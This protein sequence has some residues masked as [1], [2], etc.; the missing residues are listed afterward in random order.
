MKYSII[1]NL[2]FL[3]NALKERKNVP[4]V[5][6]ASTIKM[7]LPILPVATSSYIIY[8]LTSDIPLKHILLSTCGLLVVTGFLN[9]LD[10]TLQEILQSNSKLAQDKFVQLIGRKIFTTDYQNLESEH[11][12]T[13]MSKI[14]SQ[15]FRPDSN[16]N[17]IFISLSQVG[18]VG[19]SLLFYASLLMKLNPFIILVVIFSAIFHFY[20][21]KQRNIQEKELREAEAKPE[22]IRNH[23]SRY[24]SDYSSAKDIRIYGLSS[25]FMNKFDS[26]MKESIDIMKCDN[27]KRGKIE[28][29]VGLITFIRDLLCYGF[30]AKLLINN[31][32]TASDFVFY[33]GVIGI[34]AVSVYDVSNKL[35][36]IENLNSILSEFRSFIDIPDRLNRDKGIPLPKKDFSITLKDLSFRYPNNEEDT[37]KNLNL[38]IKNGEKI[39]IVGL[40]GAGKTTLVKLLCGFYEITSGEIL[41]GGKNINSYNIFEYYKILSAVFQSTSIFPLTMR[42]NITINRESDMNLEEI[43][44]NSGFNIEKFPKGIETKLNKSFDKEAIDISGGELQ[45][46][47]LAKALYQN[48]K[49]LILDEPTAALDPIAEEEMYLNYANMCKGKT[50]IFISHRLSSTRF[51]D[52]ILLLDNGAIAELGTHD[53]LIAKNGKYKELFDLQSHYY[54]E[55][56]KEEVK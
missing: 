22:K 1:S 21:M 15:M 42:E 29:L 39:A 16:I 24:A 40:N 52:R 56:V 6:L 14:S 26:N 25:Y 38:H 2:K 30:L 53:E 5:I 47:A 28:F 11:F 9:F 35:K 44:Q 13:Q 10:L 3:S 41:I 34:F 48:G 51:C 45:K 12:Q 33:F 4:I 54:Q 49:I 31:S 32:L 7:I 17:D 8:A 20:L 23:L 18:S 43:F 36:A 55:N 19:I 37:L 46:L 50:S 27:K